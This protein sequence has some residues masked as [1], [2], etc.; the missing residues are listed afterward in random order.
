LAALGFSKIE[1]AQAYIACD[2]NEE[3]AANLLFDRLAYG[4]IESSFPGQQ[5]N[6]PENDDEDDDNLFN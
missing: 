3:L 4:D 6:H 1:A 5:Q 2:K